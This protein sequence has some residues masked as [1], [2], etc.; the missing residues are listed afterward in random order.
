MT[1]SLAF[2]ANRGVSLLNLAWTGTLDDPQIPKGR[3]AIALR[4]RHRVADW[5]YRAK[6]TKFNPLTDVKTFEDLLDDPMGEP[7]VTNGVQRHQA[8]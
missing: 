1:T 3:R 7:T 6:A 5:L 4:P 2:C 8:A